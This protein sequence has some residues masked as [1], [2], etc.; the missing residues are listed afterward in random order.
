MKRSD[1]QQLVKEYRLKGRSSCKTKQEYIDL[2]YKN[3]KISEREKEE[4]METDYSRLKVLR[5]QPRPVTIYNLETGETEKFRSVYQ[6]SKQLGVSPGTVTDYCGKI[7][8]DE[9]KIST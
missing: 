9:I 5:W 3:N 7:Y 8:K 4:F 1:L 2:L 6:A